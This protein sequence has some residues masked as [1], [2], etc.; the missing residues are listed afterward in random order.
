MSFKA[1]IFDVDGTLAETEDLHRKAFNKTFKNRNLKWYW[2]SKTY[3]ELLKVT[4]GKKRI[5]HFVK[6]ASDMTCDLSQEEI[7][8]I[9]QEKTEH[10]L[11]YLANS[12]LQL[13]PGVASVIEKAR[14]RDIKLAIATA[15]RLINV[16]ALVKSILKVSVDDIF[17]TV[18]TSEDV[19]NNKPSPE[20]YHLSLQKLQIKA[21]HCIAIED[22][23]NGLL[24]ANGA[25]IK[26]I[27]TPS[28]YS[29][30]DDFSFAE[31]VLTSLVDFK[32]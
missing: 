12:R 27:I 32:F 2:D 15:T 4:G 3:K 18:V 17:D 6:S 9:H 30:D 24:A 10:Y 1:I 13:R 28:S 19:K 5:T 14:S 7:I 31:V 25:G 16:K 29:V 20:I 23:L 8:S 21:E 11:E 22:S 26:T